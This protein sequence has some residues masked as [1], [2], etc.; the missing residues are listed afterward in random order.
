MTVRRPAYQECEA[1][2]V[3]IKKIELF[4]ITAA[5]WPKEKAPVAF[6]EPHKAAFRACLPCSRGRG[7]ESRTV[8]LNLPFTTRYG[9]TMSDAIP[10]PLTLK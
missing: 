9:V 1:T 5:S 10:S 7:G 4:Q 8:M 6:V 2:V 3:S